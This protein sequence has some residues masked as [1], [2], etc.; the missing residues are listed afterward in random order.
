MAWDFETEPEFET[1]LEWI[2]QFVREKVEPLD[3]IFPHRSFHP[4]DDETGPLVR[5]MQ[6]EVR[7]EGLW[8]AHLG[9]ELGGKGFGQLKLALINEILG[10]S[11][12][13][14]IV[15]G[16][17]APDTG[18]AEII[19]HYGTEA[20]KEKYLQPLLN[21]E[22]FSCYSMT[23]PHAGADPKM[24]TTRVVKDGDEWVINGYKFF[25]SNARTGAL[26]H[27][28]GGHRSRRRA[29]TRACRCSWCPPTRPASTSSATS[30]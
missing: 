30:G 16:T 26:H 9:P 7:A 27:R 13:A 24:F 11:S 2:R 29:R 10:T 22:C 15:F 12:W 28:D 19:A 14:P 6:D 1:K 17:A 5:P 18:N 20:Q 8:G 23:E 3:L 4:L 21:G 25:S